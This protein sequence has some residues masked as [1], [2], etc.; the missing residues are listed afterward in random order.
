MRLVPTFQLSLDEVVSKVDTNQLY[1]KCSSPAWIIL[2]SQDK[3]SFEH[4]I[5]LS[6]LRLRYTFKNFK[7]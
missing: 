3:R 4:I 2:D 5:L 6:S 1:L 7:H